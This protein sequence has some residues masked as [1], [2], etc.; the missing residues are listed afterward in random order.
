MKTNT[1]GDLITSTWESL[2]SRF[3]VIIDIHRIMPNHFHGIII[4][5][6]APLVGARHNPGR[7]QAPPLQQSRPTLGDIIGAFKSLSTNVWAHG[8]IFQRNY[9]E[10][11]IRDESELNKIREYIKTNPA[12]WERDRNN[13]KFENLRNNITI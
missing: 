12:M 7:G 1:L 10:H 8:K 5:V 3:N 2:P 6:G 11:I 9:Y 13:P 4:I